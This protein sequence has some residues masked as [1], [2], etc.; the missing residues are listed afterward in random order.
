MKFCTK[1]IHQ[2]PLLKFEIQKW[3]DF[4]THLVRLSMCKT[5]SEQCY[6]QTCENCESTK[7]IDYVVDLFDEQN[8]EKINYRTWAVVNKKNLMKNKIN[9]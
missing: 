9:L 1:A 4:Q 2:H 7:M 5:P 8:I 6:L 3:E